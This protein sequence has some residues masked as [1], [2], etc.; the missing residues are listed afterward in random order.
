MKVYVFIEVF[1]GIVNDIEV[2]TFKEGAEKKFE[3]AT[4]ISFNEFLK[5]KIT[6]DVDD[7]LGW[8]QP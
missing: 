4:G 3:Q 2:C 8:F 1:Q 5:Q 7:I 6:Q